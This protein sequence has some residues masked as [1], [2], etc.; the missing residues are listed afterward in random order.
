MTSQAEIIDWHSQFSARSLAEQRYADCWNTTLQSNEEIV[1]TTL[2]D[3]GQEVSIVMLLIF[4]QTNF[5]R[6]LFH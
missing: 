3:D 2:I 1:I 6:S 5:V 4:Y